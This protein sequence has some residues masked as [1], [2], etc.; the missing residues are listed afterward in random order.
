M[1]NH[2]SFLNSKMTFFKYN[3]KHNNL[4]LPTLFEYYSS[5]HLTKILNHPFF[6][7]KDLSN[8]IKLTNGFTIRDK[9]IDIIDQSTNFI[10][11]CKYY[12]KENSIT[13]SKISTFLASEKIVGKK[14]DFYLIRTND[15]KIDTLVKKMID[16]NDLKD[17]SIC[18]EDFLHFISKI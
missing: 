5:I 16:R 12:S 4:F 10:G 14:L 2:I 1:K 17:I 18:R 13:Y 7:Y 3:S 8:E 9:G 15:C 6:V 11:Q